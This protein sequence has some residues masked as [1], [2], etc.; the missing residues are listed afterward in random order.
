MTGAF[1]TVAAGRPAAE[2]PAAELAAGLPAAE[3]DV[4]VWLPDDEH[5]AS[6]KDRKAQLRP[7]RLRRDRTDRDTVLPRFISLSERR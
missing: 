5:A 1:F 6:A 3:L 7:Q 2:L 4:P